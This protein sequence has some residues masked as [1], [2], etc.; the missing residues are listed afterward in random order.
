MAAAQPTVYAIAP[1]LPFV[2]TLAAGLLDQAGPEPTALAA[3]T[4][5]LPTRRAR[6]ALAEAFLRR[7]QGRPLLLPR[8]IPLGDLDIDELTPGAGEDAG[9]GIGLDV[10]PAIPPLRRQLLLTRLVLKWGATQPDG[11][12]Q[13]DQAA[14]LAAALARLMDQVQT[15]RLALDRLAQLVPEEYAR[16]WQITLEFLNILTEHWPRVLAEEGCLDPADRRNRVLEAQAEAWRRAP[17]TGP[18]IA[19]GT[20]GSIPATAELIAVVAGLERGALVLPGLDRHADAESWA[21]IQDEPSH[22]QHAIARLLGRLGVDREAVAD[23]PAPG[24]AA[25]A[26]RAR[27]ISE[28][29]RPAATSEGWRALAEDRIAAEALEGV[30]RVDCPGPREEAEVVALVMR[31]TLEQ[32]E[33]G[34]TAA[35]VTFDRGLARR[36]AAALDRWGVKVD[37]SAGIP[38]ADTAPGTF[39]RLV[40]AMLAEGLAPVPLLACLKH[41]LAAGGRRPVEFRSLA[42]RL[43]RQVLRGPRPEP[44][45]AGLIAALGDRDPGLRAWIDELAAITRPL[46]DALAAGTVDAERLVAAH[47]AVTEGLAADHETAGAERLWA[48]EAG[49]AAAG[50][51]AELRQAAAGFPAFA[52]H[53]YPALMAV[54]MAGRVVRPRYG[55][56][57]RLH[58]WGPLEARLQQADVLILGGLNEAGWPPD[59]AADPWLSRPM[60]ADFGLPPP[61]RRIGLSAHDF[62]QGFCA[63]QVVLTRAERVEGTP[64]VPS[65]WLM[66]LDTVLAACGLDPL[67][68]TGDWPPWLRWQAA[69]DRPDRPAPVAAP[70]PC[71][72]L[73]ARPRRLSV[74]QVETWM[75]D[76][77]AIYARHILR[78]KALDPLDA[79]P[80]AAAYGMVMHHILDRFLRDHPEGLPADAAARLIAVGRQA[81]AGLIGRPGVWA[82]WWPR[83]ERVAR[84]FVDHEAGRRGAVAASLTEIEGSLTIA[85][86]AGPFT[87]TAKADRIDRMADGSLAVID[88]K[89]GAPPKTKEIVA[90]YAPQLPLEAAIAGRGGFR[91]LA[92]APVG[93]LAYWRLGGGEPGGEVIRVGADPAEL[94]AAALAGLERLVAAFDDAATP[95]RARPRPSAAPRFSDYEHLARV[96]EWSAGDGEA[97][98]G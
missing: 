5:L 61:E 10:A 11:P 39:L 52:G 65:R 31:Q 96:R 27:L 14:R 50:F 92:A 54:L 25:P 21:A 53:A 90:G 37:D 60:R 70:A 64:S 33:D 1:G 83:F 7:S 94:A 6:R 24:P 95:Y 22:P 63:S 43:E 36:V 81:F 26:A 23:W 72:P 98:D 44:G 86:P 17:P 79:D 12:R 85:A 67:R 16:H 93:E 32:V 34:R 80:G 42:R 89:T 75:R 84:W 13:P 66:R 41:P 15:E 51:V 62:A 88:Y 58:I 48:G 45:F 4:V 20:T 73:A 91:G 3:F 56:H 49:E 30:T 18:V 77:Y 38:L 87:L 28:A 74:T 19:A 97:A 76:P 68:G 55:R 69:L 8:L 78:L 57:P 47:V 35:L 9:P 71:P 46:A 29:M 40:A 59:A 2:D 82:F